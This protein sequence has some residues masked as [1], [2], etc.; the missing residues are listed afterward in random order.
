LP[1][2]G[3]DDIAIGNIS[4]QITG[5]PPFT[6]SPFA[7]VG[8]DWSLPHSLLNERHLKELHNIAEKIGAKMSD[9]G[10]KG[11]FGIDVIYDE[12]RD[13]L[14]LIE[15]NAR[16]PA[17]TT[18]ESQLQ[19]KFRGHLTSPRLRQA[20]GSVGSTIFEAHLAALLDLPTEV[21][22][23]HKNLGKGETKEG[24]TFP[25]NTIEINDGAQIVQRVTKTLTAQMVEMSHKIAALNKAGYTTIPYSN[26][27][28]NSDFI[29][30]QSDKGLMEKDGKFNKRGFEIVEILEK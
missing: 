29:R 5:M 8:N 13:E 2:Y 20:G 10:W 15:I 16:Q 7:T 9:G 28:P 14:K 6:D 1:R 23:A 3:V 21:L 4:Y 12:E 24:S 25:K 11:L 22:L 18:Y 17:S 27:K 19:T 30:I 26:T